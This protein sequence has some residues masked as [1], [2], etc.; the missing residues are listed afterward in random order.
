MKE[1]NFTALLLFLFCAL[2]A[3]ESK[4]GDNT[5]II[6]ANQSYN[7]AFNE[8]GR[9]F[10]SNG[11]TIDNA[12]KDFGTITTREVR[13]GSRFDPL[14]EIKVTAIISGIE[15]VQIILTAMAKGPGSSWE[16]L[17]KRGKVHMFS[18]GWAE[19]E[20]LASKYDGE[21]IKFEKR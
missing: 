13:I 7:E 8:L 4:N 5:I 18:K 6:E 1:L 19:L 17:E 20:S 3:Q 2:A 11:F 21:S 15:N 9:L 10:V 16:Q 14:W 12:D